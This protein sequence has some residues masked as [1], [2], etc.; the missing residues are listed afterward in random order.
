[1]GEEDFNKSIGKP[2]KPIN[3]RNY[4]ACKYDNKKLTSMQEF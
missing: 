4:T 1:M 3:Y 2:P